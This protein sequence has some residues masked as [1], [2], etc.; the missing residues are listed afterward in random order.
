MQI[1]EAALASREKNNVM[2]TQHVSESTRLIEDA[3]RDQ[4][5]QCAVEVGECLRSLEHHLLLTAWPYR[6]NSEHLLELIDTCLVRIIC[7]CGGVCILTCLQNAAGTGEIFTFIIHDDVLRALPPPSLT[8]AA[9][10]LNKTLEASEWA[11]RHL[12]PISHEEWSAKYAQ[13][14]PRVWQGFEKFIAL[15]TKVLATLFQRSH[16]LTSVSSTVSSSSSLCCKQW[17]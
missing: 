12:A 13:D 2:P 5:R 1:A 17:A 7:F 9:M 15:L 4:M 6:S 14:T 16:L 10:V 8:D 3:V 11:E